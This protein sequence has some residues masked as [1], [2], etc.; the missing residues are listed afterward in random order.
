MDQN[1]IGKAKLDLTNTHI[2]LHSTEALDQHWVQQGPSH[3]QPAINLI[4]L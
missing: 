3:L 4:H 1:G 2:G